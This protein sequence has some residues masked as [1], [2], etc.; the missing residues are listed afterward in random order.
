M[1]LGKEVAEPELE[2]HVNKDCGCITTAGLISKPGASASG[3]ATM[4]P[5]P[6]SEGTMRRNWTRPIVSKSDAAAQSVQR[7]YATARILVIV[8][9]PKIAVLTP[10]RRLRLRLRRGYLVKRMRMM[11]PR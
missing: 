1:A 5:L 2:I 8:L 4:T 10:V 11:I 3:W 9:P 6:V 7:Q